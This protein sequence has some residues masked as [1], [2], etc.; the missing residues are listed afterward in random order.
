VTTRSKYFLLE[1]YDDET[2]YSALCRLC[3]WT[4]EF[5]SKRKARA[6]FLDHLCVRE[7]PDVPTSAAPD[8][9]LRA[10]CR[11]ATVDPEMFFD[12]TRYDDAIAMCNTCTVRTDC[13]FA[14]MQE[15]R[16][17]I[18]W[19]VCGGLLPEERLALAEVA[20]G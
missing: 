8:W 14:A 3:F 15:E 20:R 4:D 18:P 10:I 2:P 13:L 19:G 12:V 11:Q 1:R 17:R 7:L 6:A 9:H 16:R 5:A